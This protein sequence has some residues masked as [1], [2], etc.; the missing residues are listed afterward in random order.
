VEQ[1]SESSSIEK[2]KP[3]P[4]PKPEKLAL[5]EARV[6]TLERCIERVATLTG[7]GNILMAFGLKR[8]IPSK[9]DL[10]KYG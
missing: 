2:K 4:K 6:E 5:L 9:K 10:S 3:G 7:N 1:S 8:W